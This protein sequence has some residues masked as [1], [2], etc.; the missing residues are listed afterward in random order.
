MSE[1]HGSSHGHHVTPIP[2]LFK[3]FMVLMVLMVATI[4]AAEAPK[5]VDSLK[6]LLEYSYL[7]NLIA[8]TIAVWKATA[9]VRIFMGV[10]FATKLTKLWAIGGFVWLLLM[11]ITLI[12]YYTRPWEPVKGW[13]PDQSSALPRSPRLQ[14]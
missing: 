12:D 4:A 9:V 8:L 14:E 13:E 6:F 5:Y 10:K 11:G 3:T 7:M 2:V 1:A